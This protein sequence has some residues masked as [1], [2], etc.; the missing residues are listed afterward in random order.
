MKT[1][2][3]PAPDSTKVTLTLNLGQVKL[4]EKIVD[5]TLAD[6][7]EFVEYEGVKKRGWKSSVT[8]FGKLPVSE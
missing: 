3:N 2:T 7:E 4:L 1:K 5:S 8:G 6:V